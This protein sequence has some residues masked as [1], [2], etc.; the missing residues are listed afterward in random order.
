MEQECSLFMLNSSLAYSSTLKMEVICPSETSG[1]LWTTKR[2]ILQDY[3][4]HRRE[5]LKSNVSH[6]DLVY[7]G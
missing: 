7:Y 1:S 6:N 5:D 4:I 2:Y 3:I